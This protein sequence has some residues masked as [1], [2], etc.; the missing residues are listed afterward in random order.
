MDVTFGGFQTIYILLEHVQLKFCKPL[1]NVKK[2]MRIENWVCVHFMLV[3]KVEW[4]IIGPNFV[5]E[6]I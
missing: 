3:L 6:M 1:L 4:L 2:S 5:Q